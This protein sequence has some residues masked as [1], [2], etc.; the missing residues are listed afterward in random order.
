MDT[1][2]VISLGAGVQSSTLLIKADRG[3][4]KIDGKVVIPQYAIMSDTG[5]EPDE[6][7]EW[8]KFLQAKVKNIKIIVTSKGNIVRDTLQGIE[9]NQ[10]FASV[11]FFVVN[12]VPVY[13]QVLVGHEKVY[14]EEFGEVIE[15]PIY[16]N[17]KLL[18][19]KKKK[20]VLWRQ[21]TGEYKIAP[22]RR[23]IRNLL[24]Y[25]PRHKVREKVRL[26]MGISTDEIQRVKPSQVKWIENVFPLIDEE[27]S[28]LDCLRW[29]KNNNMPLP[30]KS[31]C[32]IC[33]Y[34]SDAHWLDMK[35]NN[36]KAWEMAVEFDKKIRRIPKINGTVYLHR[37]C[38]PLDEVEL[39]E[40]QG[41]LDLFGN[42]C[43]GMCGL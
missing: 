26:W 20:G 35:R 14:S 32:I 39:K 23:E 34:H 27:M 25:G 7:Y 8:L 13:E 6:V 21:C 38:V 17:G 15:Q 37:S 22:V 19:V 43:E 5:N 10:R 36:T 29:F 28:R 41:S 24:G 33:P 3:Q 4:F 18:E 42:E 12:D 1:I 31:S 30:P 16:E 40:N 11:P 9:N 2:D